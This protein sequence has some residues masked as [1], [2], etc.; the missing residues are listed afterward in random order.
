[1]QKVLN[2]L[3]VTIITTIL[4]GT[5]FMPVLTYAAS[6]IEQNVKTTQENVEFNASIKDS[7]EPT[8]DVNE[9]GKLN[10]NLKVLGTGY[11]KDAKVILKDNNYKIEEIKDIEIQDGNT[12]KLNEVNVGEE[13]NLNI[14]IKVNK[15]D[16]IL[17]NEMERESTVT[18]EAIYVNEKGKEKKVTKELRLKLAWTAEAKE[19]VE[20]TLVRHI[21][22][23]DNKTML[24]FRV[25][26]GIENNAIPYGAKKIEVQVPTLNEV[27]PS[28]VIVIGEN[29]KYNYENSQVTIEKENKED[30]EGKINWNSQDEYMITYIY[31]TAEMPETVQSKVLAEVTTKGKQVA[32]EIEEKTYDIRKP[33]G[34]LVETEITGTNEINKGYMYTNLNRKENKLETEFNVNYGVDIGYKDLID[35]VIIREKNSLLGNKETQGIT[36]KKV[37]IDINNLIQILGEDGKI[38]VTTENGVEIGKFY[39]GLSEIT[40]SEQ[41]LIFETSKPVKEGKLNISITKAIIDNG[42]YD[43]KALTDIK[44]M[45][46]RAIVDTYNGENKIAEQ[47]VTKKI[48]TKE[49][50]SEAS[51]DVNLSNLSTVVTN[52]DV[53]LTATLKTNRIDTALYQDPKIKIILPDEINGI[54][55]KEAEL[56]YED[57]L[58]PARFETIGNNIELDLTGIQ[59]KYSNQSTSEGT[60]I[61]IIADL[62]LNN[63]APSTQSSIKLEYSNAAMNESKEVSTEI[64]IV[65]PTEFIT[66]N[67]IEVDGNKLTAQGQEKTAKIKPNGE[68]KEATISG[69]II[70]NLGADTQG[71][72]I[73]GNIPSKKED[74]DIGTN[75]KTEVNVQGAPAEIYYSNNENEG[76]NGSNWSKEAT[77]DSKAFKAVLTDNLADKQTV[78]FSYKV[79]VPANVGYEKIAQS[80]YT[81]YYNNNA[82]DGK[83]Q[84]A[85]MAKAVGMETGVQNPLKIQASIINAETKQEIAD[86]AEVQDG[87]YLIYKLK[88]TN[89][90]KENISNI[91][92]VTDY[93]DEV[94]LV[95]FEEIAGVKNSKI[96]K[97]TKKF[98]HNISSIKAGETKEFTSDLVLIAGIKDES[99]KAVNITSTAT[100]ENVE[101]ESQNTS[102]INAI[103]GTIGVMDYLVENELVVGDEFNYT[104]EI[105]NP[106]DE[107]KNNVQVTIAI[108]EEFG[109]KST[110]ENKYTYD[111]NSNTFTYNMD[112]L[113]GNDKKKITIRLKIKQIEN[114]KTVKISANIKCDGMENAKQSPSVEYKI[115][116]NIVD[117]EYT[118][119]ITDGKLTDKDK[120]I[121]YIDIKNNTSKDI[122]VNLT[123]KIPYALSARNYTKTDS[124]GEITLDF[125]GRT[126]LEKLSIKAKQTAKI[127]ITTEPNIL[128]KGKSVNIE[129]QPKITI[130]GNEIEVK[131]MEHTIVG[132]SDF[133]SSDP[134]NWGDVNNGNDDEL[135]TEKGTYVISGVA[136][137]D[138]NADGKKDE[139]E[140]KLSGQD[141]KLYNKDT[142]KLAVDVNGKELTSK[143]S[144]VGRYSFTNVVSGN[145]IVV[146]EYDNKI[147]EPTTYKAQNLLESEDSD[148]VSTKQNKKNVAATNTIAVIDSN[149]YN[150]DLGLI[151]KNR[152]DLKLDKTIN[153]ITVTNTKDNIKTRIYD[154]DNKGIT[155]VELPNENIDTA[156][157]TVEYTIKVTNEGS[158]AGYAK[159][160]VDYL[161]SGM[162]FNS[163]LNTT[164]YVGNDGN[165]YNTSLSNTIINPGETKEIRLVLTRKMSDDQLGTIRNTAEI[166]SS[167][168]EYGLEDIDSIAGNKKTGEDDMSSADTIIGTATGKT[169]IA[170]LGIT[171]GILSVVATAVY[172]TK[173][174]VINKIV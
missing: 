141:V 83:T 1:M 80:N 28:N 21:K 62:T 59:T 6:E 167:Y 151:N 47:E 162:T 96:D 8:L 82:Q 116:A 19:K 135:E 139:T 132:T 150:I 7:Y 90:G 70:N 158:I 133:S 131:S 32:S 95:T 92:L 52:E 15:E 74:K 160:I 124:N 68:E 112:T 148:F 10:L 100:G 67:A 149:I 170:I 44:E 31:E 114:N 87:T 35:K 13:L 3:F 118:S 12:I 18:L 130:R 23:G 55:I 64:G 81:V 137:L 138:K 171:L 9:E 45:Q 104:L 103:K 27:K 117:V 172:V 144:N 57:E 79:N 126:V 156:T 39:K 36:T 111:E 76:I 38:R 84:N 89:S 143:T 145:Y 110:P 97:M 29:I 71:V 113:K 41:N 168:N 152:F 101:G 159:S 22:I 93:P 163:E 134:S 161:P 73:I 142:G 33:V 75:L 165:A 155:K 129:N 166:A 14:P 108:P 94:G 140:E 107:P 164:W 42:E 147:Y 88:I 43:K 60:I 99:K 174:Y 105:M 115:I 120:L 63:L 127:A 2:K 58:K 102:S 56:I 17:A 50:T 119:S 16:K 154:F 122:I 153:R 77:T 51:I 34:S 26:E 98:T 46:T 40:T 106:T 72:T 61:R 125:T 11:L 146:M 69:T 48:S 169:T 53:I 49:P 136:W 5:Y 173:K 37:N 85:V 109:F 24:S 65:A 78:N 25:R 123:D 157:V 20:Q 86:G 54:N 66:T 91:K 121:Y 4:V 128:E 30:A